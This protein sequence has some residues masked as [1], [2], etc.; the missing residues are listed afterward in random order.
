MSRNQVSFPVK[1]KILNWLKDNTEV[2]KQ[3]NSAAVAE[4]LQKA[5]GI[6]VSREVIRNI[7]KYA[8]I[9]IYTAPKRNLNEKLAVQAVIAKAVLEIA[10]QLGMTLKEKDTLHKIVA[11]R[12]TNAE[13][14]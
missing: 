9:P 11:R 6:V 8:E 7:C 3:N 10:E 2:V 13:E 14:K 5:T 4:L 12:R 1:L